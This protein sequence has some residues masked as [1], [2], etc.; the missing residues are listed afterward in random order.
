MSRIR[1]GRNPGLLDP[2]SLF[3]GPIACGAIAVCFPKPLHPPPFFLRWQEQELERLKQ[4]L[5]TSIHWGSSQPPTQKSFLGAWLL[6]GWLGCGHRTHHPA[7]I[8]PFSQQMV[9]SICP[10]WELGV[11]Q[12]EDREGPCPQWNSQGRGQPLSKETKSYSA[13]QLVGALKGVVLM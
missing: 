9:L 1:Q 11:R 2:R 12:E 13:H 5:G 6:S 3:L 8:W 10:C 7:S 4:N